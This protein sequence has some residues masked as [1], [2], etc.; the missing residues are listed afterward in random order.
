MCDDPLK[1]E[2][3][4][5]YPGDKQFKL[6][7]LHRGKFIFV[8]SFD[9]GQRPALNTLRDHG[10]LIQIYY[11][12]NGTRS[13]SRSNNNFVVLARENSRFIYFVGMGRDRLYTFNTVKMEFLPSCSF[14]GGN[15]NRIV[16]VS[17]GAIHVQGFN[18]HHNFSATAKLP[19]GYRNSLLLP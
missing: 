10:I 12:P 6:R 19:D 15:W 3:I 13:Y 4:D 8:K 18:T 5:F 1:K 16:G 2:Y 7:V 14:G 17:N 11:D 9:S